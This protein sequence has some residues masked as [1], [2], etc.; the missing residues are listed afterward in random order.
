MIFHCKDKKFI[1]AKIIFYIKKSKAYE[2]KLENVLVKENRK[3]CLI[4][5]RYHRQNMQKVVN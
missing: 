3:G 5:I 4:F 1:V 2:K